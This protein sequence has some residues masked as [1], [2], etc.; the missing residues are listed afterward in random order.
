MTLTRW[1]RPENWQWS[2][3]H[4]LAALR[5]EVERIFDSSSLGDSHSFYT[6]WGPALDLFEDQD[7]FI[8]KAEVPGMKKEELEISLL[9]GALTLT[10]ERKLEPPVP[11]SEAVRTE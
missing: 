7:N 1:Q 8:V 2:T 6:G 3:L 10:G 11:G 4:Q 9:E 5:D